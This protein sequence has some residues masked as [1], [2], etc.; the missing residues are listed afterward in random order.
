MRHLVLV[1][2]SEFSADPKN[3]PPLDCPSND[4]SRMKAILTDRNCGQFSNAE[5]LENATHTEIEKQVI[6]VLKTAKPS[7][8]VL[9]YYSGHGIKDDEGNAYLCGSD[10]TTKDIE[11]TGISQSML[12]QT[13]EKSR[14]RKIA[15]LVDCCFSG[16]F[17]EGIEQL[18]KMKGA[19][20]LFD[21]KDLEAIEQD[22]RGIVFMSSSNAAQV[23]H[24]NAIAGHGVFTQNVLKG[25]ETGE[26]DLDGNGYITFDELY[27]FVLEQMHQ[28]GIKQTPTIRGGHQRQMHIAVNGK[29]LKADESQAFDDAIAQMFKAG[30]ISMDFRDDVLQEIIAFRRRSSFDDQKISLLRKWVAKKLDMASFHHQWM[31][32]DRPPSKD[33]GVAPKVGD[34]SLRAPGWI[35]GYLRNEVRSY[36]GDYLVV[37]PHL[38]DSARLRCYALHVQWD[39]EEPGLIFAEDE[40]KGDYK[41]NGKLYVPRRSQNLSFVSINAGQVRQM[42][43][44]EHPVRR[45]MFGVISTLWERMTGHY[46]PISVPVLI[47]R[48]DALNID[49]VGDLSENRQDQ[50]ELIHIFQ[51]YLASAIH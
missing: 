28:D 34:L 29:K 51:R 7:D 36:E 44:S 39:E 38:G 8:T 35:G 4:V 26:A 17:G 40:G 5:V 31:L 12:Y 20:T 9:I 48:F 16:R 23:S 47:K 3:L 11:A 25:L 18:G 32:L 37:R 22:S 21:P 1:G 27:N 33:L 15:V 10:T 45:E 43:V 41:N 24:E 14:C 13:I 19:E 50:A 46:E 6:R 2:N 49:L 42:L 30:A